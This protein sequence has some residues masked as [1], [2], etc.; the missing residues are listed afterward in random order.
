MKGSFEV[1]KS[2]INFPIKTKR[3]VKIKNLLAILT[4]MKKNINIKILFF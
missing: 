2:S 1:I 4:L 3:K